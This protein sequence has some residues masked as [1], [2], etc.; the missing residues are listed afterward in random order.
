MHEFTRGGNARAHTSIDSAL[1]QI[2]RLSRGTRLIPGSIMFMD[3][4]PDLTSRKVNLNSRSV[5]PGAFPSRSTPLSC[6][7]AGFGAPAPR[8]RAR[9][10]FET[11]SIPNATHPNPAIL[12]AS[13]RSPV[14]ILSRSEK[15]W[16]PHSI[17]NN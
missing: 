9:Q 3:S 14:R 10:L 12:R 16:S 8:R 1:M 17:S 5:F 2:G 11:L 4:S 15:N 6:K 7:T 13:K